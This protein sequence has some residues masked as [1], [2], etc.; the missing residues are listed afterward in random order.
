MIGGTTNTGGAEI[1]F[2]VMLQ[3]SPPMIGGTTRQRP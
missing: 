2:D 3:W 1:L